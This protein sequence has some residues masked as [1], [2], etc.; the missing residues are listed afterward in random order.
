MDNIVFKVIVLGHQGIEN[1]I[2][3]SERQPCSL[4][5]SKENLQISTM[6]LLESSLHPRQL[7]LIKKFKSNSRYGTLYLLY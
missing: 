6:S 1:L 3:E 4:N 2:K 5:T 7:S